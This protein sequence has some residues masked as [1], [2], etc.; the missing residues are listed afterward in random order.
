MLDVPPDALRAEIEAELEYR[1]L[2]LYRPYPKQRAFHAAALTH[3]ERLF[4]AGNQ[5]GKTMSAG[6]ETAMHLTGRYP[7]AWPGR[8]WQRGVIGWAASET[9]ELTRDTVERMLLG[10]AGKRGTGMVPADAILDLTASRGAADAI[11]TARIRHTSGGVSLLVFKSYDQGRERWQGETLDLC[12]YDEEPPPAIYDEGLTRTNA[13]GGMVWLTCTP[14]Q[15][16]TEVIGRF[17]PVPNTPDRSLTMMTIEDAEHYSAEQRERVIA[18]YPEHEREARARGIP[19]LGSGR[20]FPVPESLISEPAAA[21]PRWWR[22]LCAIDFGH[23]DHPTAAVWLAH[24]PETD[25]VHIYDA[26]RNKDPGLVQHA[27]AI[28][29]RGDWIPVAWPHDGLQ[30]DRVSAETIA[31]HYRAAGCALLRG[32]ATH[33]DGGIGV[34][35]GLMDMLER[36]RTSRLRV[37]EHLADWWEEFRLY[38][39]KDG[40][41]VKLRDDLMSATRYGLMM[42]RSAVVQPS[43]GAR[44]PAQAEGG[45]DP[46]RW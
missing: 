12:W 28:R 33:A 18:S 16:M 20:V 38:H 42:L 45:Y 34:E 23:G 14:L 46:Q 4:L 10:R 22:R 43:E 27:A 2:D 37:A 32:H 39:R 7:V 29:A 3:R 6:A 5:L 35:A 17:F 21:L 44:R 41:L 40:K 25:V 13:T 24:D 9:G 8:V 15:G 36:M 30:T 11:A 31:G 19:V 1:R 26:Y